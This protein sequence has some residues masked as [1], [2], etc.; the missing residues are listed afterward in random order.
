[1]HAQHSILHSVPCNDDRPLSIRTI[2]HL[3]PKVPQKVRRWH[4]FS[5][6]A[7]TSGDVVDNPNDPILWDVDGVLVHSD[8][9]TTQKLRRHSLTEEHTA[10]TD[11]NQA[12]NESF[13]SESSFSSFAG[14]EYTSMMEEW[15]SSEVEDDMMIHYGSDF[16]SIALSPHKERGPDYMLCKEESAHYYVDSDDITCSQSS[17][18]SNMDDQH[19]I[20]ISSESGEDTPKILFTRDK[21]PS[22][23]PSAEFEALT[24][25]AR[26]T[27]PRTLPRDAKHRCTSART[28]TLEP[29]PLNPS[30]CLL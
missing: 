22:K 10:Y 14:R 24:H 19:S 9:A 29:P 26:D 23:D 3:R 25:C 27:L 1:M 11:E 6:F 2:N 5:P 13:Y 20:G 8:H 18:N 12:I 15:C 17:W 21:S 30:A 4:S 7:E 28:H 16:K